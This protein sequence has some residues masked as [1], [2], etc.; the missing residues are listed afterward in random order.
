MLNVALIGVGK[1]GKNYYR[2]LDDL[3]KKKIV[4]FKFISKFNI[5]KK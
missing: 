5:K 1:W 2:I 4:N 3:H